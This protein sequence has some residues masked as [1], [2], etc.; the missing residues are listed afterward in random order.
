MMAECGFKKDLAIVAAG[1]LAEELNKR[2]GDTLS[3]SL[4]AKA[5]AAFI[6][7]PMG[8]NCGSCGW[9][10]AGTKHCTQRDCKTSDTDQCDLY[11]H[12]HKMTI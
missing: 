4:C 12:L 3:P 8:I 6:A 9:R 2:F 5:V 7:K 10:T 1:T 11:R